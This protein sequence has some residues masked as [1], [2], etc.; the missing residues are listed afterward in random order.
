MFIPPVSFFL[1]SHLFHEICMLGTRKMAG[2]LLVLHLV[3]TVGPL[4]PLA[5]DSKLI[6]HTLT[7]ECT[8]DCSL[9]GCAPER[10][11][12]RTC[13]C[14]QKKL[15]ARHEEERQTPAC[16][17]KKSPESEKAPACSAPPCGSG[18]TIAL[19]GGDT[20][21][22]ILL[23]SRSFQSTSHEQIIIPQLHPRQT[24]KRLLDAEHA[25]IL[26]LFL[27]NGADAGRYFFRLPL[28]PGGSDHHIVKMLTSLGVIFPIGRRDKNEI[29]HDFEYDFL[30]HEY[31]LS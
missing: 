9:C 5:L 14:W 21:E 31:L 25:R 24:G 1:D 16:C 26:Y 18:K 15:R 22:Y 13:C 6:A 27:A 29:R 23:P 4:A 10:S 17:R 2:I 3:M 8:G 19:W 12:T 28:G 20:I 11:A 30:Q 7:G